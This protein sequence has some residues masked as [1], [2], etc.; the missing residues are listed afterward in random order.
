MLAE[1]LIAGHELLIL[2][3]LVETALIVV[4]NIG[5]WCFLVGQVISG[6]NLLQVLLVLLGRL[7]LVPELLSP[8]HFQKATIKRLLLPQGYRLTN[9]DRLLSAIKNR[10]CGFV[11]LVFD[12]LVAVQAAFLVLEELLQSID[13]GLAAML[14]MEHGLVWAGW[15]ALRWRIIRLFLFLESMAVGCDYPLILGAAVV[16]SILFPAFQQLCPVV[17][18]W[19]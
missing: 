13:V 15:R 10:E 5:Q 14:I 16:R 6:V 9:R 4:A 3:A 7:L 18:G 1:I 11:N 17:N 8:G 19:I 2:L 12:S